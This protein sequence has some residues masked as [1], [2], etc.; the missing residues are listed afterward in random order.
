MQKDI[1][2]QSRRISFLF[3]TAAQGMV[4]RTPTVL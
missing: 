2:R 1:L 4:A 3:Y